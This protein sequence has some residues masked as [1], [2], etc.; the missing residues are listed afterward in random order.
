[1]AGGKNDN[2]NSSSGSSA[3]DDNNDDNKRN[4]TAAAQRLAQVSRH[5]GGPSPKEDVETAPMP[6]RGSKRR[7]R[8]R[9]KDDPAQL[10]ADHSDILGQLDTLRRMAAT[11]DPSHRGYARQKQSGKL[12]VRE[13]VDQLLDPGSFVEVGSVSGEVEWEQTGP[14]SERPVKFTPS[15]NVQGF[16]KLNGRKMLF[17]ADDFSLRAGHADGALAA[18]TVYIEKLALSLQ[19]PIIKLVDGSSGGGSV[20]TIR[21]SGWSYVPPM[22]SFGHVVKQ[23]NAGIPNLG[24]VLGPAVGLGAAR[25]VACHFSVM[26]ADVG[27]M[28]NAGPKVVAGATFEEGLTPRDL[29]GPAMHTTNGSID[30]LAANEAEC[31]QQIRTVLGY[32]P[33][34]G[35][36]MPPVLGPHPPP[37]HH[38]SEEAPIDPIDRLCPELRSIIPRKRSRMYD[39]RR[40]ITTVV[41]KGSWFEI[42]A[43]W[44]TTAIVG[45]ARLGGKPVGIVSLDCEVNAGAL[46]AAGSRKINRHLRFLDIFNLPAVQFAD[47]PGYA[48]GTAAER[49]ATMRHG[50]DLAAMYYTT[51]IPI[52]SVIVRRV[53]GVAGGIMVDSRDPHARVA[54]PSGEWGSLPLDGGIEVGHAHELREIARTEGEEARRQRYAQLED[55]YR[56]LQNPVRTAN[57]FGIEEVIDPAVTRRVLAEWVA[58]MYEV[59]LPQRVQQRIA[60][61]LRPQF[62]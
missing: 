29:G 57:Q 54:W 47:V 31:F 43:L 45:L 8:Q 52:F 12:W 38:T 41:D 24:A 35:T 50:V 18:K 39:A 55:E 46:D 22:D 5:I 11:P 59:I 36:Q 7:T 56:R 32:L 34:S 40:I 28:F 6:L 25:V 15:N 51:T 27:S 2:D 21:S 26:A 1:M 20:T 58:H 30:N 37:H 42:G 17:T 23:L 14:T 3:V 49:A 33:N 62:V 48:V 16:G 9:A 53:Y 61:V 44:G 19:L 4:N 13:R 60:G 10:P